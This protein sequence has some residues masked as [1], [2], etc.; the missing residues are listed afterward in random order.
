MTKTLLWSL[1]TLIF[2][3]SCNGEEKIPKVKTDVSEICENFGVPVVDLKYRE[4]EK[5]ISKIRNS[6]LGNSDWEKFIKTFYQKSKIPHR[7][8][9]LVLLANEGNQKLLKDSELK[10]IGLAWAG[11][12][13]RESD[14]SGYIENLRKVIKIAIPSLSE[15]LDKFYSLNEKRKKSALIVPVPK[16]DN[17]F[18][19]ARAFVI[20]E[21]HPHYIKMIRIS[22]NP[23]ESMFYMST[24]IGHELV[25]INDQYKD[26][27]KYEKLDRIGQARWGL[28][29]EAKAYNAQFGYYSEAAKNH[30]EIFCK[31]LYPSWAYG[32]ILI[33]LSWSIHAMEREARLGKT[34][35]D[36]LRNPNYGPYKKYFQEPGKEQL[37]KNIQDVID[38]Y[39]L[40]YVK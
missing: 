13:K 32:D 35:L 17:D 31:W 28:I 15:K 12:E 29:N 22:N 4:R 3:S 6:S 26:I 19:G 23:S 30:P 8:K 10:R 34:L 36:Q 40:R 18:F 24:L 7:E 5:N 16:G 14:P 11:R 9:E 27:K 1:A 38:G 20:K 33:P 37:V 39:N 21:K 2:F 25:H